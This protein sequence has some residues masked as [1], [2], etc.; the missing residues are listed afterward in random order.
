[1]KIAPLTLFLAAILV[2]PAFAADDRSP[3]DKNPACLDRNG[4]AL[5]RV[6]VK[7]EPG[8]V[9]FI[10][11]DSG[12]F[13][14]DYLR[15]ADNL[16]DEFYELFVTDPEGRPIGTI[17]LNRFLKAKRNILLRDI[18]D[19]DPALILAT[20]DQ[21][22][23]AYQFQ[24]YDMPSA[25]VVD[26]KGRLIGVIM[27]DDVLDVVRDE[28]EEEFVAGV[29]VDG[30]AAVTALGLTL[31]TYL[32]LRE[33]EVGPVTVDAGT[34]ATAPRPPAGAYVGMGVMTAVTLGLLLWTELTQALP[35]TASLRDSATVARLSNTS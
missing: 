13:T 22:E 26:D 34:R 31:C 30:Q 32:V 11:D 6:N 18:L 20:V 2:I 35:A 4:K 12:T 16:P 14:I 33:P 15:D 17:P 10:T 25:G 7:L 27:G 29:R 28:V 19:S 21:E 8:N 3:Y 5:A 24:Q 9:E 1:M 23:V